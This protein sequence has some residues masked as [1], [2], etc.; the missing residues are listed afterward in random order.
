MVTPL[1]LDEFNGTRGD[2]YKNMFAKCPA[3]HP[4]T[5]DE[6]ANVAELLIRDRGA[7]ITV[8][9]HRWRRDRQ[10]LLWLTETGGGGA[11]KQAAPHYEARSFPSKSVSNA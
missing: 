5:A 4:G 2:F 3:S 10:L 7:F 6:I 1:A 8:P 9:P 11:I